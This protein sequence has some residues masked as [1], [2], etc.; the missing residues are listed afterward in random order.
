MQECRSGKV[1]KRE[2]S[3]KKKTNIG[4]EME[5][6]DKMKE[7]EE[8]RKGKKLI[9]REEEE[10]AECE[11]AKQLKGLHFISTNNRYL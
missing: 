7:E 4:R 6:V 5:E 3:R 2:V 10:R 1:I 11:K 9:E 8:K